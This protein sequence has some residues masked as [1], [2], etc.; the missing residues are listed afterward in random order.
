MQSSD[1]EFLAA[2]S[3]ILRSQHSGVR[4]RLVAIGLDFHAAGDTGDGFATTQ[5]GDV[6]ES[7]VEGG[8][9]TGDAEDELTCWSIV[10]AFGH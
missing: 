5:I 6:D 9:D 7:V 10:L 4:R 2:S 3:D 8:E 1:T